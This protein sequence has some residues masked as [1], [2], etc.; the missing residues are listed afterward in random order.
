[1][2]AQ[3]NK[4]LVREYFAALSGKEKPAS[5]VD[6]YVDEEALKHHIDF[7]EAAFPRYVLIAEDMIAADD[8]VVVRTTFHAR[9]DGEFMGLPPSGK[10][11]TMPF[12]IIY[13]FANGKIVEH[14]MVADQM[15]L[16]QQLG[17]LP[18]TAAA[19]TNA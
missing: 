13:R 11:V 4:E 9:Q 6:R 14:W 19:A 15:G 18:V 12:I 2:N 8:K 3:E 7:F 16:M 10:E 17:A 1:M 5:I